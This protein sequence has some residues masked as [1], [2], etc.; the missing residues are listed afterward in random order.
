MNGTVRALIVLR[1]ILLAAQ[2]ISF[3]PDFLLILVLQ[4]FIASLLERVPG[5]SGGFSPPFLANS[6]A[7]LFPLIPTCRGIQQKLM[8]SV[9]VIC[10][11]C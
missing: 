6:S 5:D 8:A 7:F 3:C 9:S 10:S 2:T 1:N 4:Y 11:I